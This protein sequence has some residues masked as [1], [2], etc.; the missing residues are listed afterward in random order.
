MN[1]NKPKPTVLSRI[2][3]EIG[4]LI[5]AVGEVTDPGG[6]DGLGASHHLQ[7]AIIPTNDVHIP[8]K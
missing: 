2:K 3:V 6:A 8:P 1:L 4:G 7:A 5:D